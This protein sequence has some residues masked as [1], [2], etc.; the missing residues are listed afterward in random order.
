MPC[1]DG[2]PPT[3][4]L[5]YKTPSIVR[6]QSPLL[7]RVHSSI[8][9]RTSFICSA[10]AIV[11]VTIHGLYRVL[12]LSMPSNAADETI[13]IFAALFVGPGAIVFGI[14]AL[15]G[16][17]KRWSL[18]ALLVA[19]ATELIVLPSIFVVGEIFGGGPLFGDH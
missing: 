15:F 16:S 5:Q 3:H 9:T 19:L 11:L 13:L 18:G 8:W 7:G 6:D 10:A 4:P 12:H 2:A 14:V 17:V 1:V